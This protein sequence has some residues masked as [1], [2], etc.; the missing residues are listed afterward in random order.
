MTIAGYVSQQRLAI[1]FSTQVTRVQDV[2]PAAAVVLAR[3][4][5]LLRQ[6]T[7]PIL[8]VDAQRTRAEDQ[9]AIA[10]VRLWRTRVTRN[11][12]WEP[13]QQVHRK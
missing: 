2:G 4:L 7:V 9:A 6:P 5:N 1:S 10:M 8:P 11:R 13:W 3:L 12:S